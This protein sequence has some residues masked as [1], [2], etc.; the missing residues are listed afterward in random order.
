M[1]AAVVSLLTDVVRYHLSPHALP[2]RTLYTTGSIPVW[3]VAAPCSRRT[4]QD[5]LGSLQSSMHYFVR[6]CCAGRCPLSSSP[7]PW[8]HHSVWSLLG[9]M[10]EGKVPRPR[11]GRSGGWYAPSSTLY[12]LYT[13]VHAMVCR[14]VCIHYY[15]T[16]PRCCANTT[17]PCAAVAVHPVELVQ[18]VHEHVYK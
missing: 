5:V 11:M 3:T 8:S 14:C 9:H 10:L 12:T 15:T 6:A 2:L 13:G 17:T 16:P 4:P 7:I 1:P 18:H